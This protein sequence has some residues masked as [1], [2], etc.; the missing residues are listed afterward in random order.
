MRGC[1]S[2]GLECH[3]VKV[4]VAGSS[5]V[6]PATQYLQALLPAIHG[7]AQQKGFLY[8]AVRLTPSKVLL[9]SGR[10]R[11]FL[12]S[13]WGRGSHSVYAF[14]ANLSVLAPAS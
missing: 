11:S 4:E 10:S 14:R 5:P 12:F 1:S 6:S 9:D 3:P 7:I 8:V 2:V 13:V